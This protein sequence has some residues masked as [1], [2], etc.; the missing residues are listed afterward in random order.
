ML[1]LCSMRTPGSLSLPGA[2]CQVPKAL[3]TSL[4]GSAPHKV[5][6]ISLHLSF[7]PEPKSNSGVLGEDRSYVNIYPGPLP[8][9]PTPGFHLSSHKT[10]PAL[11]IHG[12]DLCRSPASAPWQCP[13]HLIS[14]PACK[15][16]V[17]KARAP[18]PPWSGS[19]TVTSTQKLY[20][21]GCDHPLTSVHLYFEI[22]CGCVPLLGT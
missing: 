3:S 1:S 6:A 12:K 10:E 13:V 18:P 16:C 17:I 14:N 5:H 11:I 20:P 2:L 21:L 22:P 4:P 15:T 19:R 9:L 7:T 8:F